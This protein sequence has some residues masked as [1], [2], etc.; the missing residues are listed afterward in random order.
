MDAR[1]PEMSALLPPGIAV[2]TSPGRGETPPLWPA[3]AAQ[4]AAS[5]PT[6]R[7]EFAV[8]RACAHR[9][10]ARLGC[11]ADP[12]LKGSD[13][14]PCWPP[15]VIGSLTHCAAYHAAAATRDP[16]IAGL[17]IDAELHAPLP[18]GVDR[19]VLTPADR[20]A[21]P[22][23]GGVAWER[24]VFSAKESVFK[25]WWPLT[26]TWLDFADATIL[27]DPARGSFRAV[28][29]PPAAAPAT[30]PSQLA[31][32]FATSAELI[33]TAVVFSRPAAAAAASARR[34][35]RPARR[36][37]PAAGGASRDPSR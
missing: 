13:R 11:P 32:R 20:L 26:Q 23:S 28:L 7:H 37:A 34:R 25:A 29:R 27:L 33:L 1:P 16:L 12:L 22:A 21:L 5:V 17:G 30:A 3:E 8:T 15:G 2:E 31:G 9:A 10:L 24:V 6:R 36:S 14:A 18:P 35:S 19:L 4:V